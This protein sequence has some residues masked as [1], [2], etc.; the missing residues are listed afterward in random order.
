MPVRSINR[1]SSLSSLLLAL[2]V[3]LVNG[4]IFIALVPPWQHYD[5]PSHFEYA[6]WFTNH[7]TPLEKAD[8]DTK[9]R[10]GVAQSMIDH[11]F[12]E[13]NSIPLPDLAAEKPYIGPN[14]QAGEPSFYYLLASTP[15]RFLPTENV[16][17]QL[18][19]ARLISLLLLLT[20]ILAGWGMTT[21][22]TPQNPEYPCSKADSLDKKTS[23][24]VS[25]F[26]NL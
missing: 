13:G 8:F 14:S 25:L 21:E 1:L 26:I 7:N 18:Y 20:T 24:I 12:F 9:M 11:G 22:I 16:T 2:L 15:L 19:S 6:W 4:L 10:R 5:E 23:S 17:W 3:G